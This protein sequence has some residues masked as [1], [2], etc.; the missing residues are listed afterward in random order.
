MNK[1]IV[2]VKDWY[3]VRSELHIMN[4]F[5]IDKH[6]HLSRENHSRLQSNR[7][8][9]FSFLFA[10]LFVIQFV[11]FSCKNPSFMLTVVGCGNTVVCRFLFLPI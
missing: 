7:A 11:D 5:R 3:T 6:F 2:P 8:L 4:L 1:C 9:D 10:P